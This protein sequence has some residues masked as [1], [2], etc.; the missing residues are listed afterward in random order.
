MLCLKKLNYDRKVLEERRRL[1]E[2]NNRGKPRRRSCGVYLLPLCLADVLVWSC[3]RVSR[4]VESIGLAQ[5]AE[6]LKES[7]VHGALIAADDT[8]D[9]QSLALTLQIPTQ[10]TQ[11]RQT[12]EQAFGELLAVGTARRAPYDQQ[13]SSAGGGSAG[14]PINDPTMSSSSVGKRR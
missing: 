1:C 5:Y 10:D 13:R 6:N 14:S 9:A 4:W 7:G 11:S 8:F 2:H 3:D 12:L